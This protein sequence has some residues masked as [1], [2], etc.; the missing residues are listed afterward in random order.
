MKKKPDLMMILSMIAFIGVGLTTVVE[1]QADE[2]NSVHHYADN[3]SMSETWLLPETRKSRVSL[4]VA[5]GVSYQGETYDLSLGNVQVNTIDAT[6]YR[7]DY[8][9][10][11]YALFG[12]SVGW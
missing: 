12:V 6:E 7:W 4:L 11:R 9:K 8:E 5:L 1:A 2:V 10:P 3:Q